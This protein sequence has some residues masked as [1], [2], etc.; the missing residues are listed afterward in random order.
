MTAPL[1]GERLCPACGT[2]VRAVACFCGSCGAAF[3]TKDA[4]PQADIAKMAR[5]TD[6]AR[7]D[8]APSFDPQPQDTARAEPETSVFDTLSAYSGMSQRALGYAAGAA[9]AVIAAACGLWWHLHGTHPITPPPATPA[10][11]AAAAPAGPS[12]NCLYAD[13]WALRAICADV[14]LSAEDRLMAN[15]YHE[16]MQSLSSRGARLALR[17][18]QRAWLHERDACASARDTVSC[19][20]TEYASRVAALSSTDASYSDPAQY[21]AAVGTVDDPHGDARYS[22][23]AM[24][25]AMLAAVNARSPG[26]T[27]DIITWRC[28]RERVLACGEFSTVACGKAAWLTLTDRN[29]GE[30]IRAICRQYPDESCAPGTHCTYGCRGGSAFVIRNQYPIDSR[31][32]NPREWVPVSRPADPLPRFSHA[33]SYMGV[34]H[35]LLADG[36][37]PVRLANAT[38]CNGDARCANFPE[39]YFCSGVG[40]ASCEFTWQRRQESA[41]VWAEGEGIQ[42]FEDIKRCSFATTPFRCD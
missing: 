1:T 26:A 38:P 33:M 28:A 18:A 9:A 15:L 7:A 3:Q 32:Y 37:Q 16:R 30:D 29:I 36:W 24:T 41:V 8:V 23:P 39:A 17:D 4:G 14:R 22:G 34:R 25:D 21:C 19:L 5:D 27:K 10:P 42:T 20:S 13:T 12:F 40:L 11:V 2:R 31:G 35:R 6:P